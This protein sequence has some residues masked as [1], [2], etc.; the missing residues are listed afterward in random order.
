MLRP[1]FLVLGVLLAL[2][3]P[4]PG[5]A[6][7][8]DAFVSPEGRFSAAF[9]GEPDRDRSGRE[10][11][12]GPMDE[13]SY[14]LEQEGLFLR[15]EFHDVPKMARM[16]LPPGV[17][18]DLAR[19]SLLADR[20]ASN[21][22]HERVSLRGHPGLALR[23]TPAERPDSEEE[24]RLYLVGS[25]LYVTFARADTAGEAQ[26]AVRRFLASFDAWEERDAFAAAAGTTGAGM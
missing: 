10:T 11:W 2:A 24:A 3:A 14:D 12:A 6:T 25:R 8:A 26:Q 1:R 17:I 19:R 21:A 9:P 18:L 23:Y 22:S 13:G 5:H 4:P 7:S 15:V 16:L 20:E